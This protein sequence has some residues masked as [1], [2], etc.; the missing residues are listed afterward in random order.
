VIADY[1][2]HLR[3]PRRDG[4]EEIDH[5]VEAVERYAEAAAALGIAEIALTEHAY[6]FRETR[7][8]WSHPYL[9]ERCGYELEPYVEAVLEGKRRGLPVKLGVEV[10]YQ[11]HLAEETAALLAPYPWD[12]LLGSVHFVEGEAIDALPSLVGR[13]GPEEAWRRYFDWLVSAAASGIV[14]V[15]A[16]PDLV[17]MHGGTSPDPLRD[18]ERLCDACRATGTGLEV[19]TAG[20]YKP[21]RAL[22]PH[23]ELLATAR[24]YGIPI[25]LASD[26][27]D[28]RLLGRDLDLAVAHAREA[29]YETVTVFDGRETREEPL[30]P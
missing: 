28:P 5:T 24:R 11:P 16:H 30:G 23:P 9:L 15:L 12:V 21:Q 10:D 8:L 29:G 22:Y 18:Y 26:A 27:H 4:V 1:H 6:Y 3:R 14:D 7:S 17:V 20:L 25:T 13:V 2:L 19:S